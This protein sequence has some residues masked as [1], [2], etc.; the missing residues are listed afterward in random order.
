M[1]PCC[2]L[3]FFLINQNKCLCDA[4]ISLSKWA[5]AS[6]CAKS[7][8]LVSFH[9]YAVLFALCTRK[10]CQQANISARHRH[11]VEWQLQRQYHH[12]CRCRLSRLLYCHRKSIILFHYLPW[13]WHWKHPQCSNIAAIDSCRASDRVTGS[14]EL[15]LGLRYATSD[16]LLTFHNR[17]W[18]LCF[19]FISVPI[20]VW[21]WSVMIDRD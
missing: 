8:M 16:S 13:Q 3:L 10:Q 6:Y 12:W 11:F 14:L 15:S 17:R 9:S 2:L 7:P 19:F 4:V 5:Y 18:R 1:L 21:Y 20:K